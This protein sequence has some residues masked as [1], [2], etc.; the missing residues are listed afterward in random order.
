MKY[1]DRM[2]ETYYR[3]S[4]STVLFICLCCHTTDYIPITHHTTCPSTPHTKSSPT[5]QMQQYTTIQH[6][7]NT[8]PNLSLTLPYL[9]T[10]HHHVKHTS[11][12]T[13][14]T[15]RREHTNHHTYTP[16]H[17]SLGNSM[18]HKLNIHSTLPTL[19][20]KMTSMTH[21]HMKTKV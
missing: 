1:N 2:S 15:P 14:P 7:S 18:P 19:L 13:A 12:N 17:A 8:T 3:E 5:H 16:H 10:A 21:M 6:L 4:Q 9:T 20:N 11:K